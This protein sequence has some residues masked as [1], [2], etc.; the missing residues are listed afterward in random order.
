[1]FSAVP[2]VNLAQSTN[3]VKQVAAVAPLAVTNTH[4]EETVAGI[5]V[6]PNPARTT[7]YISGIKTPVSIKIYD[8]AGQLQLTSFG[9]SVA[10][11]RLHTGVYFIQLKSAKTEQVLKF[12]K[13]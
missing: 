4:E 10:V 9:K 11:D 13:Q 2:L 8:N 6:Y 3:T 5:A 12:V 7:L 1:V